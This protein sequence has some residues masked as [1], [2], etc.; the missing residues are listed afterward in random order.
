[1]KL[2]RKQTNIKQTF[3]LYLNFNNQISKYSKIPLCDRP[4]ISTTLLLIAI[5][6]SKE[7]TLPFSTTTNF[8]RPNMAFAY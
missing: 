8:Q 1:M 4:D 6:S 5:Y 3:P 2:N 7:T